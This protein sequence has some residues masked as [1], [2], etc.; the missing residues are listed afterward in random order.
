MARNLIRVLDEE[1]VENLVNRIESLN[2]DYKKGIDLKKIDTDRK[3]IEYQDKFWNDHVECIEACNGEFLK[4]YLEVSKESIGCDKMIKKLQ[5][6]KKLWRES[7]FNE[8]FGRTP[9]QT[10]PCNM[11]SRKLTIL[12]G[13]ADIERYKCSEKTI[14]FGDDAAQEQDSAEE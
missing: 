2:A 11:E 10:H 13:I 6:M 14:D 4:K 7:I 8:K 5:H 3:M 1:K 9:N 12:L